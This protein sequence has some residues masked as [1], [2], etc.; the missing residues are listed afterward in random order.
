MLP[1]DLDLVLEAVSR[2]P[3]TLEVALGGDLDGWV[4]WHLEP[5]A[6]GTRMRFEQQVS[7]GGPLA[8]ASRVARPLLVWNHQRMMRGCREGLLRRVAES[9]VGE[10]GP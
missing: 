2:E 9:R 10:G 1:Y 6:G 7:V 3:P 4:R 8:L 5:Y